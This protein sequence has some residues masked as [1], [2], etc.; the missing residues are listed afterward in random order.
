MHPGIVGRLFGDHQPRVEPSQRHD[1]SLAGVG[2]HAPVRLGD[3][4]RDQIDGRCLLRV[5]T[6]V[7]L[8]PPAEEGSQVQV[9]V[10]EGLGGE[11]FHRALVSDERRDQR[12]VVRGRVSVHEMTL[13][14][15]GA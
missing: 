9:A 6:G 15:R 1:L 11:P 10:T 7:L 5:A 3:Q 12:R 2:A 8:A 4:E 14:R 13:P